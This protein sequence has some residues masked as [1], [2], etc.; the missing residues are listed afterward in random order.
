MSLV[1]FMKTTVT[2]RD[3]SEIT[4]EWFP[5]ENT[6]RATVICLP[7]M[8]VR[9]SYYRQFAEA[10]QQQHFTAITA[11]WR[12]H[13]TSTIRP[14][15]TVDFGYE[16]LVEDLREL[17]QS[18][19]QATSGDT[20]II[21]AGHSLGGQIASLFAARFPDEIDGIF[22]IASCLVH[23]RGWDGW[24]AQRVRLAGHLFYP[25][26]KL[27]GFFPGHIIGF[28]GKEAR[29]IMYDWCYNLLYGSY[30]PAG[31]LFDYEAA[32]R[33]AQLPILA[34]SL[35]GDDFAPQRAVQ[36]LCDK[37]ASN[38]AVSHRHLSASQTGLADNPHFSWAKQ[39]APLIAIF[40]DW[41]AQRPQ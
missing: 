39:P 25:L 41:L 20:P 29:T 19:K 10:L 21:I 34:L 13:G 1:I 28:G 18:I 31:S 16:T 36:N 22:S 26:S 30:R 23:Y 27:L 12:G 5:A 38:T 2:F 35:E 33:R 17:I 40:S 6:P 32:L 9:A 14:S 24:K 8:G 4:T 11:D 37:F 7:A 15:R 3:G